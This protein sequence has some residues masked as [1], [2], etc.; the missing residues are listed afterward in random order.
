MSDAVSPQSFNKGV[1]LV[2]EDTPAHQVFFAD[3]LEQ[4]GYDVTIAPSGLEALS[5]ARTLEPDLIL[6]DICLPDIDG[7]TVC[8]TFKR[9]AETQN[10][11]VIFIS[12]STDA[13]D[14]IQAF[15][16]G[17]VD[18]LSK[19]VQTVEMYARIR[20]HL[21]YRQIQKRLIEQNLCLQREIRERRKLEVALQAS[22]ES[23]QLALEGS[24]DGIWDWDLL[25]DHMFISDRWQEI[26]GYAPG[27]LPSLR[28]TWLDRIHPDDQ[29]WV[30]EFIRY[31][32]E[33]VTP[34]YYAEYRMR[35]KD[36]LYRWVLDRGQ[37]CW[38]RTGKPLRMAGSLT[39]ISLRHQADEQLHLML[40]TG[41]QIARSATL[42]ATFDTILRRICQ[43]AQ[44]DIGEAWVIA[45]THHSIDYCCGYY[46]DH[47]LLKH[48][49]L[50]QYHASFAEKLGLPGQIWATQ[51]PFWCE[52]LTPA[53]REHLFLSQSPLQDLPLQSAYGI[54]VIAEGRVLAVFTFFAFNSQTHSR[55]TLDLVQ[56]IIPQLASFMLRN[57]AELALTEA[58]AEL[59]RLAAID[60]LTQLANRRKFDEYLHAEWS[61]SLRE[62]QILALLICDVDYFKRYND[63]Y[64]HQAGDACLRWV[65]Q[66][67]KL[68]VHRSSDLVARYGGEEFAIILP[69]TGYKG[70]TTVGQRLLTAI[71]SLEIPHAASPVCNHITISV[72]VACICPQPKVMLNQLIER[73]DHALYRAKAAG[74]NCIQ[75]DNHVQPCD[76][77]FPR[78]KV[79]SKLIIENDPEESQTS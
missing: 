62:G 18:Y 13:I 20:H 50:Q 11:P 5:L 69:N 14:L 56:T 39:D 7:Y 10:I 27:E 12:V 41:E 46:T 42:E 47:P 43:I 21:Q 61:R 31:H 26:L 70:A 28:S 71:R 37:A 15:E 65:A 73:A 29:E 64:G 6:L 72:G 67:L 66:V 36:G 48:L 68:H 24:N 16:A 55:R 77:T 75:V 52:V 53:D 34:K 44:W 57:Q 25:N 63:H 9:Q 58:N 8:Q 49:S 30:L 22:R 1:I 19:P 33:Q 76:P 45:N 32:I 59:K 2:V 74:R 38:D 17:G 23:W 4:Q 79:P 60:G 78:V 3:T 51:K 35:G 54:P 40:A